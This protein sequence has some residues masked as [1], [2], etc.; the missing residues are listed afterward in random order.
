MLTSVHDDTKFVYDSICHIVQD[1]GQTMVKLSC[2]TD[3]TCGSVHNALQSVGD[4]L[5]GSSQYCIALVN[6]G[7]HERVDECGR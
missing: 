7:G 3:N 6:T 2:V 5:C 1:S 4:L